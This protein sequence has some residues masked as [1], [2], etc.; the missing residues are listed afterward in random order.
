MVSRRGFLKSLSLATA[1][2]AVAGQAQRGF[3][4]AATANRLIYNSET[5]LDATLSVIRE[6]ARA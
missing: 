3:E 5:E 4:F 2:P 1:L 6:L